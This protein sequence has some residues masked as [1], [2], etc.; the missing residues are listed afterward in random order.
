MDE[1]SLDCN[2]TNLFIS[3]R[4]QCCDS[5]TLQRAQR[6]LRLT[7]GRHITSA[8]WYHFLPLTHFPQA[9]EERPG[10]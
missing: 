10:T 2:Q 7:Q 6:S 5:G 1:L 8:V 9:S 4:K 3:E